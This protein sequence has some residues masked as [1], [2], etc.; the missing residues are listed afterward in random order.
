MC[1]VTLAQDTKTRNVIKDLIET[2]NK[3]CVK[4]GRKFS[5]T[6]SIKSITRKKNCDDCRIMI[7]KKNVRNYF[8]KNNAKIKAERRERY[9]STGK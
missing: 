2:A 1:I 4:C 7:Q 6:G 5:I 3:K 8:L 9:Y